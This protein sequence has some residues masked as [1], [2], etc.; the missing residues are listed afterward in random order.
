MTVEVLAGLSRPIVMGVLLGGL[1]AL[2]TSGLSMVFGVMKLIN[3]AHG[4]LVTF[5]AYF[6]H[7]LMTA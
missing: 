6:A 7:A 1:Y 4:D 5:S 2:I 3:V